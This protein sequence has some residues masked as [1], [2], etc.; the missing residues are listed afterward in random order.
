M[1][2]A[3][4]QPIVLPDATIE[5]WPL[6]VDA[7]VALQMQI[8]E[9]ITWNVSFTADNLLT[10]AMAIAGGTEIW[11]GGLGIRTG[12]NASGLSLGLSVRFPSMRIGFAYTEHTHLGGIYGASVTFNF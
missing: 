8:G 3:Y 12:W 4:S 6:R 10:P 1:K 7:G 9:Q 11:V 2:N 5:S